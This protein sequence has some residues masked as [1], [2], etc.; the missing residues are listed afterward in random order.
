MRG[1]LGRGGVGAAN[2]LRMSPATWVRLL[3]VFGCIVLPC[4]TKTFSSSRVYSLI[5]MCRL[6]LGV[7]SLVA[8]QGPMHL[9]SVVAVHLLSCL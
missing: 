1:V 7:S 4:C 3:F 8:E 5:A 2:P 9:N 6:L